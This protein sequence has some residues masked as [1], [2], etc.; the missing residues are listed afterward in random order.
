[1]III[2][3]NIKNLIFGICFIKLFGE[4]VIILDG[5][6]LLKQWTENKEKMI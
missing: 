2:K 5:L 3:V 4:T 6:N 1:M